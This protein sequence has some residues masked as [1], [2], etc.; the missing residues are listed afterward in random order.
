MKVR[1]RRWRFGINRI[2]SREFGKYDFCLLEETRSQ[3]MYKHLWPVFGPVIKRPNRQM[4][5]LIKFRTKT[6]GVSAEVQKA[7]FF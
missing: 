3:G 1:Y 4:Q 5:N 7:R 2:D 6:E